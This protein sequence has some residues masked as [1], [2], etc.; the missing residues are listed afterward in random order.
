MND[1][2]KKCDYQTDTQTDRQTPDKVIPIFRYA[3]EATQQDVT[4]MPDLTTSKSG[5][6]CKSYILSPEVY[7]V[8]V[9]EV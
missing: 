2:Q 1:Y 9:S 4:Q 6:V 3:S 7:Y 5:K 8:N